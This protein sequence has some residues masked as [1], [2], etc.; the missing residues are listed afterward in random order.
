MRAERR[1]DRAPDRERQVPALPVIGDGRAHTHQRIQERA[2][3][4]RVGLLVPVEERL[5]GREGRQRRQETHD[6]PG[7]SALDATALGRQRHGGDAQDARAL[8][9]DACA[10]Y[11]QGG[12]EQARVARIQSTPD[13]GGGIGDG[14]QVEGARRDRLRT[15]HLDRGVHGRDSQGSGPGHAHEAVP[16]RRSATA[17]SAAAIARR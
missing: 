16:L 11:L 2:E 6:R 7:Q 3:R 8:G 17:A 5:L 4:A 14:R 1:V 12:C 10:H 9:L 15:R 13:Q